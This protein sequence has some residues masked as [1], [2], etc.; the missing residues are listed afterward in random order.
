MQHMKQPKATELPERESLESE[1]VKDAPA[2]K[3]GHK[4]DAAGYQEF[5]THTVMGADRMAGKSYNA[6][7][8][9]YRTEARRETTS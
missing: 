1:M 4:V 6:S 5:S 8:F 7:N 9:G 3:H 2:E